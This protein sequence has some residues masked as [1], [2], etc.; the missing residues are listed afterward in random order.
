MDLSRQID[1]YC[2]RTGPELWSE[3]LNALTNAAF[4]IAGALALVFAARR[5]RLDGPVLWLSGLMIVI[6]IGSFLFHTFAT[7]WAAMLDTGPIALFILSYFAIAMRCFAG[8]SWGR[9]LLAMAG[10]LAALILLSAAIRPVLMPLIGSSVAYVPA[11]IGLAAVGLWLG[12]RGRAGGA[13]AA[14][15]LF[16]AAALFTVSLAFRALDQPLCGAWETGT[17]FLW[18]LMNAAVLFTLLITLIRHGQAG[19]ALARPGASR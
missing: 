19:H 4:V 3:P 14:R 17:H 16:A 12:R 1:A 18:H 6:G 5:G 8:L 15:G 11:L 2:E 13:G 10:F 7:V 9:S